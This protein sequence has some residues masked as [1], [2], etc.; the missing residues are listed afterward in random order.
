ME[1]LEGL[2]SVLILRYFSFSQLHKLKFVSKHWY[3]QCRLSYKLQLDQEK[4]LIASIY[5]NVKSHLELRQTF[6]S[7]HKSLRCSKKKKCLECNEF[8][9]YKHCLRCVKPIVCANC[10]KLSTDK[11]FCRSCDSELCR[12]CFV[13]HGMKRCDGIRCDF[14]YICSGMISC[15]NCSTKSVEKCFVCKKSNFCTFECYNHPKVFVCYEC[16]KT[17]SKCPLCN[18]SCQECQSIACGVCSQYVCIPKGNGINHKCIMISIGDDYFCL[19]CM[20]KKVVSK[21]SVIGGRRPIMERECK[22]QKVIKK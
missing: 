1:K 19:P 8:H 18:D 22:K 4:I 21:K 3:R 6:C 11:E 9:C 7:S 16:K 14:E 15:A 13:K 10:H 17:Q 2:L 20:E 12:S 5:R